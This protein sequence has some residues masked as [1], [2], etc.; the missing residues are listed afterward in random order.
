V[1]P[2]LPKDNSG[3]NSFASEP[4]GE[5]LSIFF[6]LCVELIGEVEPTTGFV[7]NVI[8]IDRHVRESV[9][10]VFAK[11]IRAD[12]RSG[13]HI[14]LFGIARLLRSS[15]GQLADE[16]TPAKISKL[17]LKLNPFRK[18]GIDSED[19]KMVY[20]SEKFEFA[21]THTLWNVVE[22]TLKTSAGKDNFHIGDFERIVDSELIK[23]VDHKNLN[24]ELE[25]FSKTNPTVENIAAFAWNKLVGKFG[26][27]RQNTGLHCVTVWET[28]KTCC[29]YFGK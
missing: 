16:F 29:S 12:F 6:E 17:S 24:A 4:P 18:I 1:N 28:D 9:V 5:G 10:P 11:R 25:E 26:E 21:A 23:L 2:F 15:W 13:R 27:V 19:C 8:D 22:V 3:F 14:G 7:V 20:F